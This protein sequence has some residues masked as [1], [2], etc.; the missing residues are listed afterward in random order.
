MHFSFSSGRL[1][2]I[3]L[4]VVFP[5]FGGQPKEIRAPQNTFPAGCSSVNGY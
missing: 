1:Q 3:R 5:F 2:Q 4:I